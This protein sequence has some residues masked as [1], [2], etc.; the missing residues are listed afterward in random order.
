[1][2]NLLERY[3]A[4]KSCEQDVEKALDLI[5]TTY[6]NGGKVLV[7][8]NGGSAADSE[9]IVGELMKGFM[10][11]REVEDERISEHLRKNLQGALPAISLPSQSAILSAFINDVEPEMMFAQLVYGYGKE[12]DLLIC[13]STSG[14]SKNCV[15]A[16]EVAKGIGVKVLSMTGEK[17]SKLSEISDCTIKVPETETFKVQEYHLP[18]YHYLCAETEKHFF[19]K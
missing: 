19:N 1:M 10:L 16:A 13:L 5:I 6:K 8:G 14:N 4:L 15:N 9:H 7:C 18:V 3:P 12:N 11:K 17:E 2:N